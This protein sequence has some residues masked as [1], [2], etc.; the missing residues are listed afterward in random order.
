MLC[1]HI[2]ALAIVHKNVGLVDH[3]GIYP[4]NKHIRNLILIQHSIQVGMLA[5]N[6]TFAWL[7]NQSLD[8]L[9]K[10]IFQ[11]S[12][13]L[14]TAVCRV[15]QNDTVAV[16]CKHFVHSLYQ[17]RKNIIGNIGGDY[18]NISRI[19]HMTHTLRTKGSPAMFRLNISFV[20]QNWQGL[21]YRMAA[22]MISVWQF[23]FRRKFLSGF[24]RS[25]HDCLLQFFHQ[26]IIFCLSVFVRHFAPPFLLFYNL[27][28]LID[29]LFLDST[30]KKRLTS[31]RLL[32]DIG[33]S[34]FL[35]YDSRIR[36][37]YI[38]I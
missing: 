25:A 15:F 5:V 4:L 17:P 35:F 8:I 2:A 22:D 29:K 34:A 38:S 7:N 37:V 21:T 6:L 1:N 9:G 33:R 31:Q 19:F 26:G 32:I 28:A 27:Y 18:C 10:N 30:Q 14:C 24:D 16:L 13:F 3:L 23:I 11:N 36:S 12:F 20:N